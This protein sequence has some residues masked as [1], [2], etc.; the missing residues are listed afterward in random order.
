MARTNNLWEQARL[1]ITE[2]LE[3]QKDD[4]L[5]IAKLW[6]SFHEKDP[7]LPA[8][9]CDLL[10]QKEIG[11]F[12]KELIRLAEQAPFRDPQQRDV[13]KNALLYYAKQLCENEEEEVSSDY[14]VIPGGLVGEA[15]LGS[16]L[17]PAIRR[18]ASLMPEE[19]AG[20]LLYF[21]DDRRLPTTKQVTLQSIQN[22]F[23]ISPPTH[24]TRESYLCELC[25]RVNDLSETYSDKG[26]L[27]QSSENY[28][29]GISTVFANIVLG[30]ENSLDHLNRLLDYKTAVAR[31]KKRDVKRFVEEQSGIENQNQRPGVEYTTK[32]LDLIEKTRKNH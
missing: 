2:G 29:L 32:A 18:Y 4:V 1:G 9:L 28:A 8:T 3:D 14:L 27:K 30:N 26:F 11:R 31:F 24:E 16:F 17:W 13:V 10:K 15:I 23:G 12:E 20:E 7:T 5:K 22:V 19:E 25:I 21:L 6:N